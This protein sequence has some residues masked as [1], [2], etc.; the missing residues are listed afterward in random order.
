VKRFEFASAATGG[1][2]GTWPEDNWVQRYCISDP[3]NPG[4]F[5]GYACN[6][7]STLK[8]YS[9]SHCPDKGIIAFLVE[10]EGW[11]HAIT[12]N[13][14]L[15]AQLIVCRPH[16]DHDFVIDLNKIKGETKDGLTNYRVSHSIMGLPPEINKW[17]WDNMELL[18][19]DSREL[20]IRVGIKEDFEAQ[21]LPASGR[22]RG[23]PVSAKLIT[24]DEA[25]SGKKMLML[26]NQSINIGEPPTLCLKPNRKYRLS[27]MMK[28]IDW[29]PERRED[30]NAK[31]KEKVAA[32]T[33]KVERDN[34]KLAEEGKELKPLPVFEPYGEVKGGM[35]YK[36][37]E[38]AGGK[39]SGDKLIFEAKADGE[40]N[41]LTTE[42]DSPAW[43]PAIDLWI[44][45]NNGIAYIDDFELIEIE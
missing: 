22:E 14:G 4:K 21:P 31:R 11:S 15:T 28:L 33:A 45:V 39:V 35:S 30:E 38:W 36:F 32:D 18:H 42:F 7:G 10:P 23:H 43:G 27:V 1:R 41:L 2:H 20:M 6:M 5:Y 26:D 12:N 19:Q 17:L 44:Y 16:T 13:T 25:F 37:F 40:W 24:S 8:H 9:S 34:V 29:S 3:N